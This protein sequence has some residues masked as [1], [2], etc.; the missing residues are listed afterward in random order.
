MG[1]INWKYIFTYAGTLNNEIKAWKTCGCEQIQHV[2]NFQ[3]SIVGSTMIEI[4]IFYW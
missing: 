2:N 3:D 1:L 4:L